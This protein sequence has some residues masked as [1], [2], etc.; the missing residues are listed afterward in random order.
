[1]IGENENGIGV[2]RELE[3]AITVN[4]IPS[5][6]ERL[7]LTAVTKNSITAVWR[8]PEYD[9]GSRVNGYVL[10]I[11]EKDTDKFFECARVK[12]TV[13][14]HTINNLKQGVEY[15]LRVRA[16]NNAGVSEP[17]EAFSSVITKD[18]KGRAQYLLYVIV[19]Q[20]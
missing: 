16:R 6:P 7:E 10:E 3:N 20:Y 18:E 11:A 12:P 17:R 1:M 19:H 2:P 13:T 14:R 9:G 8:K 5:M 4:E 15:E